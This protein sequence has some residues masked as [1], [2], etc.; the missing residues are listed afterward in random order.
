MLVNSKTKILYLFS[1][2]LLDIYYRLKPLIPRK[3]QIILRRKLIELKLSAYKDVWPINE[4]AGEPPEGWTGWPQQKRF[5]LVL[6]H[7]VETK[8]GLEKCHKIIELEKELGFRSSFN[9]VPMRYRV[10]LELRNHLTR[11]GFEVGVHGLYHDGKL[12]S[13]KDNFLNRA[14]KI[15]QYLREWDAVGFRSPAMH[16]NLKWIH[17]LEIEYDASTFD[18]DPFEPQPEGVETIFP[19][20][21]EDEFKD[22]GYIELPYTFPQDFTLFILMREKNIEVL[23][24]KLDWIVERGG[25]A[26]LLTHPDYMSFGYN[27][28]KIDTYPVKYYLDFLNYVKSKYKGSYCHMIPKE[29]AEFY[30]RKL[31]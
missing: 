8:I 3:I 17:L 18:T 26:L 12:Y 23:K 31:M 6:T 11:A 14:V 16:H 25:M 29:V 21:V 2:R 4:K 13:S 7:D 5:A 27:D 19:F 22:R 10:S 20:F 30:R 9:F 1:Q 15:N 28:K 24:K